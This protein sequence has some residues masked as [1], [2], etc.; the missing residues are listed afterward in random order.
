MIRPLLPED[1]TAIA[2]LILSIL[3]AM[4]LPFLAQ[5]GVE[6]TCQ[7]LTEAIREPT[8]R[9]GYPRGLVCIIEDTPVGVAF[10]YPSEDEVMV[11]EPFTAILRKHNLPLSPLFHD[12]EAFPNE[13]YLDSIAVAP[14]YQGQGIGTTLLTALPERALAAGKNCIGL[15]V[16]ANN[17]R[18]QRL[19]S[20]LGYHPVGR[21]RLSNHDYLHMQKE[22]SSPNAYSSCRTDKQ[23]RHTI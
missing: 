2:P 8:Y 10:G 22:L 18:A 3:R 5:H 11:D 13:W 23:T 7:I 20:Q 14:N 9:F 15:N 6:T 17:P 1:A 4:Q 21:R 12:I 19:Y 16:A